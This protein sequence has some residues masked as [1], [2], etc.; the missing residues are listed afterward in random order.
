MKPDNTKLLVILLKDVFGSV[1]LNPDRWEGLSNSKFSIGRTYFNDRLK[2]PLPLSRAASEKLL[3][4]YRHALTEGSGCGYD[5][6]HIS[7]KL[8]DALESLIPGEDFR[9]LVFFY[10]DTEDIRAVKREGLLSALS[11]LC[12]IAENQRTPN[13]EKFR[14]SYVKEIR[15]EIV[16]RLSNLKDPSIDNPANKVPAFSDSLGNPQIQ[17]NRLIDS[18]V[19]PDTNFV[20]REKELSRIHESLSSS[21]NKLFLSGMGG[22]GK[23]ELARQYVS[24]H[25]SEYRLTL[26]VSANESLVHTI[27]DD[28]LLPIQGMSRL[29]Y[30]KD[31]ER[32]YFLRKC[33]VLRELT[34]KND[35]I[36]IDN[37]DTED[38]DGLT[39]FLGG[40]Y[41]AL[42]TTR[43]LR[44]NPRLRELP[45]LPLQGD[46]EIRKLFRLEY[47]RLTAETENESILRLTS[48]LGGHP[49]SIRLAASIMRDR[50][51]SPSRMIEMLT[52]KDAEMD[53][54]AKKAQ[55]AIDNRIQEFFSLSALS[56]KEVFLL[57]NLACIP[58]SGIA[59][60]ELFELCEFEDFDILERLIQ[61]SWVIHNPITDVVH[62]HPV[63]ATVMHE[64]IRMDD[65]DVKTLLRN[66]RTL[67]HMVRQRPLSEKERFFRYAEYMSAICFPG[68]ET[69]KD[70]YIFFGYTHT[71]LGHYGDAKK[72]FHI[73]MS[74]C[75]E[76]EDRMEMYHKISQMALY[77]G[78]LSEGQETALSGLSEINTLKIPDDKLG[79]KLGCWKLELFLRLA[80][81]SRRQKNGDQCI[82]YSKT[83]LE[84]SNNIFS[85]DFSL[86]TA[87]KYLYYYFN[88]SQYRGWIY[89]EFSSG[90]IVKGDSKSAEA[91]ARKALEEFHKINDEWSANYIHSLLSFILYTERKKA[92]ALEEAKKAYQI[93]LPLYGKYGVGQNLLWLCHLYHSLNDEENAGKMLTQLKAL[94][95]DDADVMQLSQMATQ[96]DFLLDFLDLDIL[97]IP[98][99]MVHTQDDLC[100]W[101][102]PNSECLARE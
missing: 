78:N 24:R 33:R 44:R 48:L 59:S 65:T 93:I 89:Y 95:P 13:L 87:G 101:P 70:F 45:I 20:G 97:P 32:D 4:L 42:F 90:Y 37:Y 84:A 77:I 21:N 73:A 72:A 43:I 19:Y 99:F 47:L 3:A 71:H 54:S 50:R 7:R 35:L 69:Q 56:P 83:A 36:V 53:F 61:K 31:T 12:M 14:E 1:T 80:G 10:H 92:E 66:I 22:I 64:Q 57:K 67:A 18:V 62:L 79:H 30:P 96:A 11:L 26:W 52:K 85:N 27:A 81:C 100:H 60:E 6:I 17:A 8:C 9:Y 25:Q 76:L 49:L 41:T 102:V 88:P 29:D 46:D 86:E 40:R 39:E 5:P 16:K 58:I 75:D 63:I 91:Y 74:F 98:H 15:P 23:S 38:D 94:Y 34:D 82:H 2:K 55:E 68:R 51:I 28:Y